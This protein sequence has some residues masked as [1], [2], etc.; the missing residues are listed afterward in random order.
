MLTTVSPIVPKI[1]F[2]NALI[3]AAGVHYVAYKFLKRGMLALPTIRNTPGTDLIVTSSDGALHA[4]IQV[5]TTQF[6]RAKF[7]IICSAKKFAKLPYGPND[8]YVLLRPRRADDPVETQPDELEGFM[9]TAAEAKDEMAAQ[10]QYWNNKGIV[11]PKFSLCIHVDKGPR[12]RKWTLPDGNPLPD[13]KATWRERWRL[14][15]INNPVIP[16]I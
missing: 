11:I 1:R 3:G 13:R 9:L 6:G 12:E 15:M 16:A 2:D 10:L 7:W 14:W 4:N 8:Y 5:K